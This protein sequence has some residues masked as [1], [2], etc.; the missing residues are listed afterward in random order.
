MSTSTDVNTGPD[1]KEDQPPPAEQTA[2]AP[3]TAEPKTEPTD[4][5]QILEPATGGNPKPPSGKEKTVRPPPNVQTAD[6][7]D[8]ELSSDGEFSE[9][10]ASTS[11]FEGDDAEP[12]PTPFERRVPPTPPQGKKKKSP[13]K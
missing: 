6:D 2:Q 5:V 3:G 11:S 12:P 4:S 1:G 8:D 9:L 13:S 7:A 10:S